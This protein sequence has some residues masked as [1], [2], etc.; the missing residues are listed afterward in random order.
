MTEMPE[1]LKQKRDEW[2]NANGHLSPRHELA[3]NA[4]DACWPEAEKHFEE[5]YAPV[6]GAL[7]FYANKKNWVESC[8]DGCHC[9]VLIPVVNDVND[10]GAIARAA[11]E[12]RDRD[13]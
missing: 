12:E 11:L 2:V 9:S 13:E 4:W 10:R 7:R 3:E 8:G 1:S 5:K 6:V